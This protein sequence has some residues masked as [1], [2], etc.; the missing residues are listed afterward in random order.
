MYAQ[1]GGAGA[2]PSA[3]KDTSEQIEKAREL[4]QQ[5][6]QKYTLDAG[7]SA[8]M[9]SIQT[10]KLRN[11]AEIALLKTSNPSLYFHKMKSIQKGT[12][13]SIRR[14]LTTTEQQNLFQETQAEQRRLRAEKQAEL[15]ATGATQLEIEAALADIYLE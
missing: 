3:K 12:Q 9:Y 7:Q 10:R 15:Q 5:I 2:P 6:S 4:T 8:K 13:A 1:V 14:M 11:L